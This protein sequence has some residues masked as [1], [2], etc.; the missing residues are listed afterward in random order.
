MGTIGYIGS[1]GIHLPYRTDDADTVVPTLTN[2][3][4]YFPQPTGSGTPINPN[5]GRIDRL[6]TDADSYYDGMLIGVEKKLSRHIQLQGSYTWQKSIDTGSSTIAGDQ[7]SN[8]P[9]SLPLLVRFQ[10]AARASPTSTS[11]RMR[12]SVAPTN[13]RA[14]LPVRAG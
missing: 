14:C 1:R 11:A 13:C 9:S 10:I 6:A 3:T 5:V 7:F 8:S 2:G 12:R 4:Y